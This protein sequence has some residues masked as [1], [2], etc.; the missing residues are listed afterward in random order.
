MIR[1]KGEKR[2]RNADHRDRDGQQGLQSKSRG[3][4]NTD[5][6]VTPDVGKGTPNTYIDP[7]SGSKIMPS[8]TVIKQMKAAK[9]DAHSKIEE[10][11]RF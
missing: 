8:A 10:T 2:K 5:T 3:K 6:H 9:L 4:T 1:R 11:V 7:V